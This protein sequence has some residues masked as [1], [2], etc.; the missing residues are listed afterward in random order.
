MDRKSVRLRKGPKR[1]LQRAVNSCKVSTISSKVLWLEVEEPDDSGLSP[2]DGLLSPVFV[3]E[4]KGEY[5]REY[6]PK[7]SVRTIKTGLAKRMTSLP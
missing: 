7:M 5:R 6:M 4:D 3:V 1:M 2:L